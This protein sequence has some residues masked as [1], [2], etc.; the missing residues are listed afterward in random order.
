MTQARLPVLASDLRASLSDRLLQLI[1]MPTEACNFRCL[2]CYEDFTHGRMEPS[3]VRGIKALL[4]TRAATLD[5]ITLSWFGG[6]PLLAADIIDDILNHTQALLALHPQLHLFSDITSNGFKLSRPLFERLLSLG[7][8][9]YQ[10]PLDGPPEWHD[11]KRVLKGGGGTFQVIWNNLLAMRAVE[12]DF[13]ILVRLHVDRENNVALP[14]FIAEYRR[15]FG[16]DPRFK[17]FPRRVSLLGGPNDAVLP[18][19]GDDEGRA[20]EEALRGIAAAQEVD[21]IPAAA[22]APICYAA[23]ANSFVVR[24]NGRLNKCTIALEEPMNQ[25]GVIE[26]TGELCLIAPKMYGWMRGLESGAV[27]ELECPMHGFCT[28][29]PR[30]SSASTLPTIGGDRRIACGKT[31][32]TN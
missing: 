10:I 28:P 11:R 17:L 4:S 25:V 21:H 26:E 12:K 8:S 2:Y 24:S 29:K 14:S 3:V 22:L 7:I 30:Q 6:E 18:V 1:I 15:E 16:D 13:T 9:Q 27:E 19:F 31:D 23:R 32:G 20:A 5:S